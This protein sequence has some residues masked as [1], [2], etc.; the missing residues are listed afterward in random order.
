LRQWEAFLVLQ[1][2]TA[3]AL[4][5]QQYVSASIPCP[6]ILPCIT[7]LL[8]L[9]VLL[10]YQKFLPLFDLTELALADQSCQAWPRPAP[11]A[12]HTALQ[13]AHACKCSVL[14]EVAKVGQE[15][16]DVDGHD[17]SSSCSS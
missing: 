4:Q 1:G 15:H 3:F 12:G 14:V 7:P 8:L 9:V 13:E 6:S 10:H 5:H 16:A 11:E 17:H 2:D